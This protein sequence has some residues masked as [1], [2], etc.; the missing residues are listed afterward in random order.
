MKLPEFYDKVG[1]YLL[2]QRAH[3]QTVDALY[4]EAAGAA[5][6]TDAERLRIYG[7]FCQQHRLDALGLNFIHC[8]AAVLRRCGAAGWEAL[9]DR[10]FRAHP[11][12]HFELNRNG[13][14]F[15]AFVAALCED[16]ETAGD[17]PACLPALA[18][19]EWWEWLVFTAPDDPQD[20]E[21]DSGPLRLCSTVEMRP[22]PY[23]FV[24]WIDDFAGSGERPAEPVAED[25]VVLF[26][27]DRSLSLRRALAYPLEMMVI[28]A[29]I[30]AVPLDSALAATLGIPLKQLRAAVA[31][32]HKAGV[33]LGK[34]PGTR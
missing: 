33:L 18:D 32:L 14:H 28:K 22:Y 3:A 5:R 25:T 12:H 11:M 20:V 24:R 19:F 17:L 2:G 1:P 27:R 23:D 13:A 34:R 26:W 21:P 10:Y 4:G 15:P 29:V 30:E 31:D 6:R 9:V 16:P 7:E 8:R